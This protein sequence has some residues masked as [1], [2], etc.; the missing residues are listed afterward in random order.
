MRAL[1]FD[2]NG[3]LSDDEG[4]QCEIL[5]ELFAAQGKPLS[6]HEYFD[7]LA[8]LSDPEIVERWL[9]P[10]IPRPPRSSKRG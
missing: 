2:F 8:G 1:L 10:G 9:G 5:Q 6:Q 3:T 7:R 4:I